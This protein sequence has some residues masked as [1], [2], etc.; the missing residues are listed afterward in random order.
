MVGEMRKEGNGMK[1]QDLRNLLSEADRKRMEKAFVE[2]YETVPKG[3]KEQS[4]KNK[5]AMIY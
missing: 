5:G 4:Y 1:V 3:R 2:C